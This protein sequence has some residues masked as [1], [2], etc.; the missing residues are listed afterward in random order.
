MIS[1]Y[2]PEG[3]PISRLRRVWNDLRA[4]TPDRGIPARADLDPRVMKDFLDRV[5]LLDCKPGQVDSIRL[6]GQ[7]VMAMFPDDPR[8]KSILDIFCKSDR[9]V[10]EST[11]QM[12]LHQPASCIIYGLD[13]EGREIRILALPLRNFEMRAAQVVLV[14]ESED[15]PRA[16]LSLEGQ[17]LMC[18]PPCESADRPV[19]S[20][21]D[22]TRARD[23]VVPIAP[24]EPLSGPRRQRFKVI[25]GDK[26]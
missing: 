3:S 23:E 2:G 21:P 11:L 14:V 16:P 18:L 10:L 12:V 8:G 17:T 26:A 24:V 20:R 4:K 19:E 22:P 6:S 9:W 15:A 7:V 5:L 13:A 1:H 25:D